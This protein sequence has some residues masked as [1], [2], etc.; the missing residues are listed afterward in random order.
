VAGLFADERAIRVLIRFN[1][2]KFFHWDP[3]MKDSFEVPAVDMRLY[4]IGDIHGRSDLLDKIVE[5]IHRDME[6]HDSRETLTITLGDYVDRGPDSRG[7]IDRLSRNPFPAGY[8]ALR[9]NHEVLFESFLHHRS[10]LDSWRKVGGFET[11]RSYGVRINN[12]WFERNVEKTFH[13]LNA[14]VPEAHR[15][16]LSSLKPS[17]TIGDYFLCHAGVRPGIPLDRQ[18]VD[19]LYWIRDEFLN[20]DQDF[21]KTIIHCHSPHEW[22]EVRP[23]RVNIDTGAVVTDRLTCLVIDRDRRRF[24]FTS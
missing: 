15:V 3:K 6:D 12:L 17:I 5:A 2:E 11:L 22:P 20:S 7:V 24:I 23:N 4:I 18:V 9:G 8:A 21:G 16:F 10:G 19:D 14:A 1:L 13:V